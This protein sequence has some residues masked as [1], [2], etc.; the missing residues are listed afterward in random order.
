MLFSKVRFFFLFALASIFFL[1]NAAFSQLDLSNYRI[2]AGFSTIKFLGDPPAAHPMVD[3]SDEDQAYAGGS[4]DGYEPGFT[5]RALFGVDRNDRVSIPIAV[6][7]YFLT[8]K[9]RQPATSDLVFF[10]KN[11]N[12]VL[13]LSTG[14]QYDF[15][16]LDFGAVTEKLEGFNFRAYSGLEVTG[17]FNKQG[18]YTL[19]WSR[20]L[21]PDS[22]NIYNTKDAVFRAGALGRVGLYGYLYKNFSFNTSLG[23]GSMNIF[24]RSEEFGELFVVSRYNDGRESTLWYANIVM[25]FIYRL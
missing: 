11:E 2:S 20:R 25:S 19:D 5:F 17:S 18:S 24:N 9:E 4:Y 23:V 16:D 8:S 13:T 14:I 7:Y 12:K 1:S 3:R 22:T 15:F 10:L 21:E 6:D